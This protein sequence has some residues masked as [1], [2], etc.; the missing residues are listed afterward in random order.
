MAH[1]TLENKGASS[2][3]FGEFLS[4]SF[5]I[6]LADGS[7]LST[8]FTTVGCQNSNSKVIAHKLST[9]T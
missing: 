3:K 5:S 7:P 4:Y 2:Y 1:F 6:K 8:D 9:L